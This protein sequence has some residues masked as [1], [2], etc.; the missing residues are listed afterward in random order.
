MFYAPL[1]MLMETRCV[2]ERGRRRERLATRG[3]KTTAPT[4]HARG[5]ACQIPCAL[6]QHQLTNRSSFFCCWALGQENHLRPACA[7]ASPLTHYLSTR[8]CYLLR[9]SRPTAELDR[10]FAGGAPNRNRPSCYVEK[11]ILLKRTT[12]DLYFRLASS[13]T[14]PQPSR[15]PPPTTRSS[16]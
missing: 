8:T 3:R 12:E 6:G 16:K 1:P 5:T 9:L 13:P 14:Q 2:A 10:L 7:S 4:I 11:P 15:P